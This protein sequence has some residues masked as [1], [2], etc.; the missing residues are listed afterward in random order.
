M[1]SQIIPRLREL[2]KN[3]AVKKSLL[4]LLVSFL[5]LGCT[6]WPKKV[7]SETELLEQ[8]LKQ[9]NWRQVDE[10]P[11]VADC[12]ALTEKFERQQCF[13]DFITTLI[14]QK[15]SADTLQL[16][17]SNSDTLKLKIT[18]T[19]KA[20]LKFEVAHRDS[21]PEMQQ[22]VIDSVLQAR[23]VDFPP[24]TPALKRGVPV[25][26]SFVVPVKINGS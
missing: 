15:L 6:D 22:A 21:I 20:E 8:E 14:Q 9:V 25:T 4:L 24:I 18:I 23:L 5:F 10:Y 26:S 13:F 11:T 1:A 16:S 12:E 17:A 3:K 19:N 7:P 2:S